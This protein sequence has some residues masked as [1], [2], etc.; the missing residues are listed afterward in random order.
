VQRVLRQ[1]AATVPPSVEVV[2]LADRSFAD[3]VYPHA[4][5][6]IAAQVLRMGKI[7]VIAQLGVDKM[8]EIARVE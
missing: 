8:G 4:W 7:M 5:A 6:F 3:R 2:V 1:V